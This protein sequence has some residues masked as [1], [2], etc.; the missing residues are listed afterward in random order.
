MHSEEGIP[1]S[2]FNIRWRYNAK[3]NSLKAK[4]VSRVMAEKKLAPWNAPEMKSKTCE[5]FNKFMSFKLAPPC[6]KITQYPHIQ[7]TILPII[8]S[9]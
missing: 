9:W 7:T 8:Y 4:G 6:C 5:K 3:C 2:N 1:Y